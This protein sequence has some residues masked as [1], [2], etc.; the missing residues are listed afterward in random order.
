LNFD[1]CYRQQ[2]IHQSEVQD[3]N[4]ETL[5][6]FWVSGA[7]TTRTNWAPIPFI[8]VQNGT[9]RVSKKTGMIHQ[10]DGMLNKSGS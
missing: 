5:A 2:K 1:L 8:C 7:L 10:H 4:L 6:D 3:L 9:C